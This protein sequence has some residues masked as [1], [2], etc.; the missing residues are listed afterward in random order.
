[1]KKK[2]NMNIFIYGT[3]SK[4]G[5]RRVGTEKKRKNKGMKK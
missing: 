1:M 2:G 3:P 4:N 5:S